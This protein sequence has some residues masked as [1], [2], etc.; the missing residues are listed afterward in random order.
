MRSPCPIKPSNTEARI[1]LSITLPHRFLGNVC[2]SSR[3]QISLQDFPNDLSRPRRVQA[4][5]DL[6]GIL[7]KNVYATG[8]GYLK[9]QGPIEEENFYKSH[10]FFISFKEED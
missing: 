5:A 1:K 6:K 2:V 8:G 3:D 4:Q 9:T 7:I 10:D